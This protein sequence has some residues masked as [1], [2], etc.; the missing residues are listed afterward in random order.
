MATLRPSR[1]KKA[2]SI[3]DPSEDGT[4]G[5]FFRLTFVLSVMC[6]L[7]VLCDVR[8]LYRVCVVCVLVSVFVT[9]VFQT[10]R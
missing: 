4:D 7:C 2:V 3:D 5:F 9:F 8:V 6:C 10:L 1:S